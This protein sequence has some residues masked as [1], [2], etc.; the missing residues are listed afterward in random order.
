M[1]KHLEEIGKMNFDTTNITHY[2]KD[3]LA[4]KKA[5]SS[6]LETLVAKYPFCGFLQLLYCKYLQLNNDIKLE[7]QIER[8]ALI[9][10]DRKKMYTVLFQE[11]LHEQIKEQEQNFEQSKKVISNITEEINSENSKP[12]DNVE[13][14]DIKKEENKSSSTT[15]KTEDD[16]STKVTEKD[17]SIETDKK[18]VDQ[19]ESVKK[20]K[21]QEL[22]ENIL[23]EAIRSS[24]QIDINDYIK[25]DKID[26]LDKKEVIS[27]EPD[28]SLHKKEIPN[29]PRAFISWFDNSD[30]NK[31]NKKNSNTNTKRATPEK[32][33]EISPNEMAKLS[34][35]SN[36]KFVTETLAT[37]YAKQ[38][39]INKAIE[40]YEQLSLKNP[41]KKTFFA[42]RVRFLKE[43]QKYNTK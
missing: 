20:N 13:L 24:I 8:C 17:K 43:K 15:K 23:Q 42:S 32:P 38:G 2:L 7:Q 3:D 31:S 6:D 35:V 39:Q 9:V 21:L 28:I 11:K 16:Y 5:N 34:L 40:I 22:E 1:I 10:N 37:I 33:E 30:T 14:I 4:L 25:K 27:L 41:E 19:K 18:V 26:S 36:T 29:E 12:K